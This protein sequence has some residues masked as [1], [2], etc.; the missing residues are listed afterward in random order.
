MAYTV[1]DHRNDVKICSKLK[2]N[3]EPQASGFTAK[4]WTFYGVISMV[5][6]SVDHGKL[7][8]NLFFTIT[9]IFTKNQK[10]N[11]R[12]CV[13]CYVIS[14]VYTLINH[15]CRPISARGFARHCKIRNIHHALIIT[16]TQPVSTLFLQGGGWGVLGNDPGFSYPIPP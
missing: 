1:I 9:F 6:K 8:S 15:S 5:Y 4:F 2:W 14:V 16:V 12:H 3:H 13:T 10:Q 7:W 11:N